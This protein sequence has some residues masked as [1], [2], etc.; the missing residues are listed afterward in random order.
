MR[1]F[2]KTLSGLVLAALTLMASAADFQLRT[3]KQGLTLEGAPIT[4]GAPNTGGAAPESLSPPS[5]TTLTPTSGPTAGGT[6]VT[7]LGQVLL[8]GATVT[9]NGA[10]ATQILWLSDTAVT[11]RTPA[12]TWGLA[13]IELTNPDGQRAWLYNA[14]DYLAPAPSILEVTPGSGSD[15][16][17][18]TVTLTGGNFLTGAQVRF[19]PVPAATT[20]VD[21]ATL[22]AVTPAHPWGFADVTVVNPDGQTV[23]LPDWFQFR[24]AAPVLN[25]VTPDTGAVAGGTT[26]TLAGSNFLSGA[27]LQIDGVP[28]A[29]TFVSDA[30]LAATLPAHDGG[31]VQ[32]RVVN[33]DNRASGNLAFSYNY[34]APTLSGLTPNSATEDG[35][36]SLTLTG[37]GFRSGAQ[38]RLGGLLASGVTVIS[39]SQMTATVPAHAPG[40][41]DV[42]VVNDD[43][44]TAVLTNGFTY[45]ALSGVATASSPAFGQTLN[46]TWSGIATRAALDWVGVYVPG[47]PAENYLT[48]AYLP[49]LNASGTGTVSMTHHLLVPG[50]TY[51]LRLYRNDV[52]TLAATSAPFVLG[53]GAG[54]QLMSLTATSG[55]DTGGYSLTL[56]GQRFITGATVT[57]GGVPAT[58][59]LVVNGNN[60]SLTSPPHAAGAVD[61]VLTNPDGLSST[62]VGGY[63]YEAPAGASASLIPS[64][65]SLSSTTV[66]DTGGTLTLTGA[67]FDAG[68]TVRL[69]G[70]PVSTTYVSATQLTFVAPASAAGAVS[71]TVENSDGAPSSNSLTLTYVAPNP[72]LASL[73]PASTTTDGGDLITVN[74]SNFRTGATVKVAGAAVTT[75]YVSATQVRFTSPA[76]ALGTAAVTVDNPG[77]K[78][79]TNSL[80]LTYT[81]GAIA[82]TVSGTQTNYNLATALTNAGYNIA[83]PLNVRVTIA[84]GATVR[85]D[86][87]AGAAFD[88]G[89]L[90]AG[91]TVTIINN[92][93]I[94]GMGGAGGKADADGNAAGTAGSPGGPAIT[95][96]V[97]A[98]TIDNANGYVYGGGGGGGGGGA[99]VYSVF[100]NLAEVAASGGGGGQSCV[101][102]A[103]GAKG[104]TTANGSWVVAQAGASS[105]G[106]TTAA[107]TSGTYGS[108][109]SG[110]TY[111]RSGRGGSGG[112][113]GSAGDA[114]TKGTSNMPGGYTF[115]NAGAGGAAGKAVKRVSGTVTFS[116]GGDTSRVKGVVD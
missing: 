89:N 78:A 57:F 85:A 76:R 27:A 49:N 11:A 44:Q 103:A 54:P 19:G 68:T 58:N 116:A 110:S 51:E 97:A 86:T 30:E 90:A 38:V 40:L 77:G 72:T 14:F 43:G 53:S 17:G 64:L 63:T 46:Y 60:L 95:V 111:V 101:S 93:K 34:A 4:G 2:N 61:V 79:S 12:N 74:G 23:T 50:N 20:F 91:S 114:G 25:S 5:L 81:Q 65:T 48:F 113:W 18:D 3:P 66:V 80:T 15:L 31:V 55:P 71:V 28:T 69:G 42:Q 33:P 73:S 99:S 29:T 16:G 35:G 82:L 1:T 8:D 59:L 26:V 105:A 70:A 39:D 83:S 104:T 109:T 47:A 106:T 45:N 52:Y 100:S 92:G 36:V 24:H 107:G 94:C 67:N 6:E 87:T 88:T 21:S 10:P 7:L 13:D 96:R 75:T 41:V 37:A 112:V 62:L 32:L 98:V 108:V 56:V 22:T 102:S 84:S 9:F 115:L